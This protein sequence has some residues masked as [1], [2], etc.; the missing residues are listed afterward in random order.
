MGNGQTATIT[1]V[2]EIMRTNEEEPAAD[3]LCTNPI[4]Q[5]LICLLQPIL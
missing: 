3:I 1:H 4:L 2:L 5:P